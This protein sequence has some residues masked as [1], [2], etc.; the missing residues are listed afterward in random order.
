MNHAPCRRRHQLAIAGI[1][2]SVL[3]ALWLSDIKVASWG[4]MERLA[5]ASAVLALLIPAPSGSAGGKTVLR[6]LAWIA[7]SC[8]LGVAALSSYGNPLEP[9][10]MPR[11]VSR[12]GST[13]FYLHEVT[14]SPPDNATE[15]GVYWTDVYWRVGPT[16]FL[17]PLGR[18]QC[19]FYSIE[20]R[21]GQLVLLPGECRSGAKVP[22]SV[23]PP[24]WARY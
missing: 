8:V 18:F 12:D 21:E 15:C 3:S 2:A 6:R 24:A 17:W 22:F 10:A 11:P 14:C 16:P 1:I 4:W 5:V 13:R 9:L 7:V 20:A 19:Y 23:R